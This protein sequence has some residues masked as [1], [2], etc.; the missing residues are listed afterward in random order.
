MIESLALEYANSLGTAVNVQYTELGLIV[1]SMTVSHYYAKAAAYCKYYGGSHDLQY[2]ETLANLCVLQMYNPAV[3]ACLAFNGIAALRPPTSVINQ[4]STW[5]IGMPWLYYPDTQDAPCFDTSIPITMD[6][7]EKVLTYV[8]AKYSLNG[9]WLGNEDVTTLFGYCSRGVP[10]TEMGGGSSSD[11][12]WTIFGT[13][14]AT[15]FE[16]DLASLLKKDQGDMYFYDL[17]LKDTVSDSLYAVPV[18]LVNY[19]DR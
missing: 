8:V 4:Q 14:K 6:L 2:C 18:R 12:S 9:T 16:C 10:N 17:F 19:A 15:V 5:K 7:R 1:S 11:T 13:S 3:G